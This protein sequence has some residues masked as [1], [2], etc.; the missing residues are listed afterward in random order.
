MSR[1]VSSLKARRQLATSWVYEGVVGELHLRVKCTFNKR[2][3]FKKDI[4]E[5]LIKFIYGK[6][7]KSKSTFKNNRYFIRSFS[8]RCVTI[9]FQGG[10]LPET[11]FASYCREVAVYLLVTPF[12]WHLSNKNSHQEKMDD[13]SDTALW[14]IS[15]I[16]PSQSDCIPFNTTMRQ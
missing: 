2:S 15:P 11:L 16:T 10:V 4:I 6:V 13:E 14:H 12:T 1:P 5:Y 9:V 8:T 7:S 3:I